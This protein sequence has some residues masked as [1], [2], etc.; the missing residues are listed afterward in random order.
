MRAIDADAFARRLDA[1]QSASLTP[2][3]VVKL[4]DE[5]PTAGETHS[6]PVEFNNGFKEMT[7]E[8]NMYDLYNGTVEVYQT[9][10]VIR[11]KIILTI[12][13]REKHE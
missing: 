11:N 13:K 3:Q 1:V 2:A 5:E 8:L 6:T 9:D 7:I 12:R 4:L 10:D